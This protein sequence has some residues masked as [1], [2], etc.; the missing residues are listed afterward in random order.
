SPDGAAEA[1]PAGLSICRTDPASGACLGRRATSIAF[2]AEPGEV[3]TFAAFADDGEE[4][5]A[6]VQRE[7]RLHVRFR[8]GDRIVGSASLPSCAAN[9]MDCATRGAALGSEPTTSSL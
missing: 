7:G 3:T 9:E 4:A 2:D 1:L 6:L 5:G 8:Q